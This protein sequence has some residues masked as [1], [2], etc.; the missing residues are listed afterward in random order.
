MSI[1]HAYNFHFMVSKISSPCGAIIHSL[2]LEIFT[3]TFANIALHGK[4]LQK[5]RPR[6]TGLP[7]CNKYTRFYSE[8]TQILQKVICILKTLLSSFLQMSHLYDFSLLYLQCILNLVAL[9]TII[10]YISNTS[11]RSHMNE[12]LQDG[13]HPKH[14]NH[15]M[16]PS[17]N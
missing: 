13:I 8:Y 11:E 17:C 7:L 10:W 5:C 15:M 9:H 12:K 16:T 4:G 6:K 1:W 3:H 14:W 2:H